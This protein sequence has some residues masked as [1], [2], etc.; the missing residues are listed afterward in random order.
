MI[1]EKTKKKLLDELEKIGN[2]YH[3]CRRLGMDPS[4]YHRWREKDAAFRKLSDAA[5][6]IGR[7]NMT[8]IGEGALMKKVNEEDLGAIKYLL[9]HNSPH[10]KPNRI[11]KVVMEHRSIKEKIAPAVTLEDVL[12]GMAIRDLELKA[13]RKAEKEA[14]RRE[15]WDNELPP[16]PDGTRMMVWEIKEHEAL[17]KEWRE[18]RGPYVPLPENEESSDDDE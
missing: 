6:R 2:A 10:Y 17:V 4:T 13:M 7:T 8:D 14:K 5:I 15:D 16:K 12:R 1:D 18:R 9:G 11:S 3:A